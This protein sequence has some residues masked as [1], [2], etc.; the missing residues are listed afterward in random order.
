MSGKAN[1]Q[2]RARCWVVVIFNRD[3][4]SWVFTLEATVLES[5][6]LDTTGLLSF[7]SESWQDISTLYQ[8][9]CMLNMRSEYVV[10]LIQSHFKT[11]SGERQIIIA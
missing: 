11:S 8:D 4:T 9:I 3:R 6:S 5:K 7:H 1:H 10:T 2:T